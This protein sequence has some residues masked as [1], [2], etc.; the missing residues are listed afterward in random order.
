[1]TGFRVA[2]GGAQERYGVTPDLCALGKVI[3]GG[4]PVGAYGGPAEIMDHL[5]PVGPG[6]SGGHPFRQIPWPRLRAWLL[7][8]LSQP[9]V[10]DGLEAQ[11]TRLSEGFGQ[12]AKEAGIPIF[13]TQAG[14]MACMFFHEGPIET[15]KTRR[16]RTPRV[17][18]SFSGAC[19]SGAC[20]SRRRSMR[21][22]LHEH[23]PPEASHIP[24]DAGSSAG[25]VQG[26]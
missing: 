3:G 11:M 16:S 8:A 15:M 10:I 6:V 7:G 17:T 22:A 4:L 25:S 13:Q 23:G 5:S 19:W 12:I 14:S 18:R 9:G 1:M 2:L 24:T 26:L 20:I 21:G